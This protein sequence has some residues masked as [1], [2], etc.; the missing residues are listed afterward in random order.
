MH[1]DRIQR[2]LLACSFLLTLS[3]TAV[4]AKSPMR[5]PPLPEPIVPPAR[6]LP[7][8]TPTPLPVAVP[9]FPS[10]TITFADGTQVKTQSTDGRFQLVGLHLSEAVD[11]AL[12]FPAV[13]LSN[14]ASTQSLDGGSIISFS[15]GPGG[16]GTLASMRFRAGARPGLYRVLVP[17]L[18][19]YALLQ[20]W[21]IDPN[22]PK[23]EPPVLNPGH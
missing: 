18:G 7:L 8:P 21:I 20:F 10:A 14:S 5:L 15:K 11:I 2:L 22:N 17:G 12:E 1:S 9:L 4:S 19:G 23:A 3:A 16:A 13:L 6:E